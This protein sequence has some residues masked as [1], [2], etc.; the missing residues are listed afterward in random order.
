MRVSYVPNG[1]DAYGEGEI[2]AVTESLKSGWLAP[3]ERVKKFEEAIAERFGKKYAVMVNSGSSANLL[4]AETLGKKLTA[5]PA[6]TFTTTLSYIENPLLVDIEEGTYQIDFDKLQRGVEC[7]MVP[8]LLGNIPDWSKAPEVP[9]IEDSCDTI[10]KAGKD[11]SYLTTNSFYASHLITAAGAGGM[12]MTN[13][14]AVYNELL[15]KRAWGRPVLKEDDLDKRF[16]ELEPGF[17]YDARY[18]FE[19]KGHNLQPIELQGAFGLEQLKRLDHNIARRK[20]VFGKLYEFFKSYEDRFILPI[21]R[22]GACWMN[23]PLTIREG[24]DRNELCKY[25]E[26]NDIQTRPIFSGNVTRQPAFKHLKGEFPVADKVMQDGLLLGCHQGMTDDQLDY[27]FSKV[28]EYLN[29]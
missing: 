22:E 15:S 10:T 29:A 11:I 23:F 3:G 25:L 4:A 5:T 13:H 19:R 14:E 12:V 24:L 2:Q 9:V 26:Q 7:L 17:V 27:M 21:T 16:V 6:L 28:K 20:E 1:F 8:N 18:R